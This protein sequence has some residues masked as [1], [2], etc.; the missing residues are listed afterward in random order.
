MATTTAAKL[1]SHLEQLMRRAAAGAAP[2]NEDTLRRRIDDY[3]LPIFQWTDALVDATRSAQTAAK[4]HSRPSCVLVGLSCVQ[5]GGKT[6]IAT[7]LEELLEFN[8]K[9]CAVVS[10]DD[11][12]RTRED[13]VALAQ[14][15]P[16]NPLLQ[17]CAYCML[18]VSCAGSLTHLCAV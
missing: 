6:T 8:G 10:L 15:N 9:R 13:Q 1:R 17:V 11:V 7:Y 18:M 2:V 4:P 16:G 14:A 12:Y 5:G 3:Y